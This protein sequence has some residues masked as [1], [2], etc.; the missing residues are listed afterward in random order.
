MLDNK[1]A[2]PGLSIVAVSYGLARYAYGL[3]LPVFRAEFHLSDQL[4]A[5]TAAASYASYFLITIAGI[6]LSARLSP[7]LSVLLGGLAAAL[8]MAIIALAR[9]PLML[10]AGVTIAGVSPGLAY[11]PF[12]EIIV[13]LVSPDRQKGLYAF[14]NSGTSLGVMLS[15]PLAILFGASW[16][17]AWGLFALT[18]LGATLW[19]VAILPATHVSG[20]AGS[21]RL[22]LRS[23]VSGH[24]GRLF[25]AAFLTGIATS[26]YW[27]FSV[28]LVT[29]N[30]S[31]LFVLGNLAISATRFGPVFWTFVGLA[32]FAGIA[33]GSIVSRLGPVHAF[34]LFQAG[35]ALSM[36]ILALGQGA[37]P[38]I[39][40]GLIFGA[41]FVL[42]AATLGLWSLALF[43]DNAAAG[44]GVT[45]LLLSAGQFSGPILAGLLI[46]P[47][48]LAT[49]FLLAAAAALLILLI[50]PLRK[51]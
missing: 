36:V 8:G 32:G 30:G 34:A 28:D 5:F 19:M 21:P 46:G 33:A 12:S 7:R 13:T 42:M 1:L 17:L 27:S 24:R 15:G 48:S 29:G 20:K 14:I 3:F 23:L 4:L 26:I 40:S 22:S 16:R 37:F 44:F 2:L 39:A 9:D 45:F 11:T 50:L 41:F 38:V 43:P 10:T 49:L 31:G 35:L 51:A 18:A 47:V 6:W 25:V